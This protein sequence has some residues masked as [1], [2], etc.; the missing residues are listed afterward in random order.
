MYL[1]YDEIINL[2]KKEQIKH[3]NNLK[4][5]SLQTNKGYSRDAFYAMREFEGPVRKYF[6]KTYP[7][8]SLSFRL[9]SFKNSSVAAKNSSQQGQYIVSESPSLSSSYHSKLLLAGDGGQYG[10]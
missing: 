4:D 1:S 5:D 9:C 7:Y 6:A 3:Q 2:I 10:H 8:P